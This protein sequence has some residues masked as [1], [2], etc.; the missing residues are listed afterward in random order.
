VLVWLPPLRLWL[1]TGWGL[2]MRLVL[3]SRR[4]PELPLVWSSALAWRLRA[5]ADL[6]RADTLFLSLSS[7]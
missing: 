2:S 1:W 5:L 4:L 3:R 6:L 7:E